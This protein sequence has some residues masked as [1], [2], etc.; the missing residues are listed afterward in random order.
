[1]FGKTIT[2][3]VLLVV[4]VPF[5]LQV[6]NTSEQLNLESQWSRK[7]LFRGLFFTAKF[8]KNFPNRTFVL[9]NDL[10][11][12]VP[13]V[14]YWRGE[15]IKLEDLEFDRLFRVYGDDQI[16]SRYILST[17]LMQR[18]VDFNRKAKRKV[19]SPAPAMIST[20]YHRRCGRAVCL[21]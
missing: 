10:S 9:P 19:G 8:A 15:N 12:R 13:L 7:T 21:N 14:N 17:S 3:L 4:K 5:S 18:L 1:M 16:E 11:N 2:Y 6:D 20:A